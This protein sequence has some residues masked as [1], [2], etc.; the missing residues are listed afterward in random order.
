MDCISSKPNFV[1]LLEAVSVPEIDRE[2]ECLPDDQDSAY[3]NILHEFEPSPSRLLPS[4]VKGDSSPLSINGFGSET[5][6]G[7]LPTPDI[8][9]STGTHISEIET[10]MVFLGEGLLQGNTGLSDIPEMAGSA[11]A[12]DLYF[13]EADNNSPNESQAG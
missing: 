11:E 6:T 2:A 5:V 9:M 13:L 8:A 1:V 7:A 12:D 4:P 10:P 3:D